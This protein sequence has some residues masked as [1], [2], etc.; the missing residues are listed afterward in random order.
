MTEFKTNKLLARL[1]LLYGPPSK[2]G[3]EAVALITEYARLMQQYSETELDAAADRIARTRKF[4]TW[5]TIG[6]CIEALEDNRSEAYERT[7]PERWTG[8]PHPEW[9]KAA[10]AF[11]DQAIDSDAGRAAARQGWLLALHGY[12]RR[13]FANRLLATPPSPAQVASMMASAKY[14]ERCSRG[15]VQMGAVHDELLKLAKSMRAKEAKLS[16]RVLHGV[17]T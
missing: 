13:S 10:I 7:A 6:E 14:V 4:K 15:E 1:G 8:I 17:V 5:P 16:E 11:A 2:D 9:S 12:Y 3:R